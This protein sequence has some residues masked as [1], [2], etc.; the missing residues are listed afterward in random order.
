MTMPTSNLGVMPSAEAFAIT[1]SSRIPDFWVDQPRVWFYRVEAILAPQKLSD[2][3]KFDLVISKLPKD[4]IVQITDF[5]EKPPD[6]D[7]LQKLKNKL[8]TLFEDSKNRQIEKLI[9]EMELGDQKPSQL[10]NRMRDLARDK[11]PDDT[12][13]VLW[14]GHLPPTIKA[15]LVVAETK[16]LNSLA[17]IADNVAEATRSN[18]VAEVRHGSSSHEGVEVATLAAELAKINVRLSNI[19]RSRSRAVHRRPR[20]PS[21]NFRESSRS[22]SK[23]RRPGAP[24][25]LCSYHFRFRQRAHKCIP[26]CAWKRS[27]SPSAAA[28]Q[29]EN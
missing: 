10:L 6:T 17:V 21:R 12:L 9:G 11:I 8:L 13:R 14:Q 2:E 18:Q 26:P 4:V 29:P 3:S 22:S 24:D 15:V 23:R 27:P 28:A 25:W 19:E 20:T 16:D 7:K 1:V 5:L